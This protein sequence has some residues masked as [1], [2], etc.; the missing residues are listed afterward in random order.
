MATNNS[1]KSGNE[2]DGE[3]GNKKQQFRPTV[4]S[5]VST[6]RAIVPLST[7]AD[8]SKDY[9]T[10]LTA[11]S[12]TSA[13]TKLYAK[14]HHLK[15]HTPDPTSILPPSQTEITTTTQRTAQAR[16]SLRLRTPQRRHLPRSGL[17]NTVPVLHTRPQ[18]PGLQPQIRPTPHRTHRAQTAR[19]HDATQANPSG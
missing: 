18:R 16:Q 5:S 4:G 9:T 12:A 17:Q 15:P 2:K 14:H 1:G 10:I 6:T 7:A 13:N 8:G 3:G 11:N 19:P